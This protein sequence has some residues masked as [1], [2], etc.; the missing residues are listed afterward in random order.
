MP[1]VMNGVFGEMSGDDESRN[2]LFNDYLNTDSVGAKVSASE[3]LRSGFT[4][5]YMPD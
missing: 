5:S 3:N 4:P 2:D 1:S